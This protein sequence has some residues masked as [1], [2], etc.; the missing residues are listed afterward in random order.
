MTVANGQTVSKKDQT[1]TS[2]N[3]LRLIQLWNNTEIVKNI[4]NMYFNQIH[5]GTFSNFM[6][7]QYYCPVYIYMS[8]YTVRACFHLG[9]CVLL[10]FSVLFDWP[11]TTTST[12]G[13][14]P[15]QFFLFSFNLA[16]ITSHTITTVTL[17]NIPPLYNL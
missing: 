4:L 10:H 12:Y 9:L 5:Y 8:T 3:Y 13:L 2:I 15:N 17:Q 14:G 11:S 7:C 1:T 16:E 6:H